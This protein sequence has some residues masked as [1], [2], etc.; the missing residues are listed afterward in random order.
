MGSVALAVVCAVAVLHPDVATDLPTPLR[1]VL[2]FALVASGLVLAGV[3][4][5][6]E[7]SRPP[8][9]T[10]SAPPRAQRAAPR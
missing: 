6:T 4:R 7:V 10:A 8:Q 9:P 2:G 3:G 5:S 1:M